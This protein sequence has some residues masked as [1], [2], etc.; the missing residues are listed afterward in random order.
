MQLNT[1]RY[2]EIFALTTIVFCGTV[3]YFTGVVAVLWLPFFMV[4]VMV[5]LLMMQS[6][7]QPL[8][9]SAREKVVL[10]LYLTFI[11]LSLCATVLQSGI[12]TAI[13]GFK[14]ELALSLVMFCMLLGMFRESQLHRLTQLFYWLFYV[15]FPLAIYQVLVVVPKRVALRGEDE[16]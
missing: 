4:L 6:R 8:A 7:Q 11:I 16:K 14:N 9:L 3:Q 2:L 10:A 13:V 15:Q 5:V 1:G 12:V